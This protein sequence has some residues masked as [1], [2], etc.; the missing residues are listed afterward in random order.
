[1]TGGAFL[2]CDFPAGA[3]ADREHEELLKQYSKFR[4][5]ASDIDGCL[6]VFEK[7]KDWSDYVSGLSRLIKV[8]QVCT[9]SRPLCIQCSSRKTIDTSL[10]RAPATGIL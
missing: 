1:M 5:L 9:A 2:S 4:A 10:F 3:M 8:F 6:Q 7:S